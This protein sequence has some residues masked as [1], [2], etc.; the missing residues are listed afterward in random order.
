MKKYFK[1]NFVN[2]QY[3]KVYTNP[4]KLKERA[5]TRNIVEVIETG[6]K[7]VYFRGRL[8]SKTEKFESFNDKFYKD[9]HTPKD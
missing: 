3:P 5:G 2:S 4:N 9:L 1:L 8:N 6:P 7:I